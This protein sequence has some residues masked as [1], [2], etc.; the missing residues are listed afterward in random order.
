MEVESSVESGKLKSQWMKEKP[1]G[2]VGS[3]L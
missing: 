3:S 2:G 1:V